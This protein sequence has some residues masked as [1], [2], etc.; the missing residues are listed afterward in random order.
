MPSTQKLTAGHCF[1]RS[2]IEPHDYFLHHSVWSG[3]FRLECNSC[4]NA[5]SWASVGCPTWSRIRLAWLGSLKLYFYLWI[6]NHHG[7]VEFTSILIWYMTPWQIQNWNVFLPWPPYSMTEEAT[8][9]PW[10]QQDSFTPPH[11][12]FLCRMMV[13]IHLCYKPW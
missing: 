8:V 2:F 6:A 5:R 4:P 11:G 13:R 1:S 3:H 10:Q 9:L 12:Q 7:F